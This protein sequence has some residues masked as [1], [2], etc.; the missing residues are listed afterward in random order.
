MWADEPP[1]WDYGRDIAHV[2][3]ITLCFPAFGGGLRTYADF[4]SE[5]FRIPGRLPLDERIWL[6]N[7]LHVE[8][9]QVLGRN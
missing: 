4:A 9:H 8:A 2:R 6:R 5:D 3:Q 1:D 7:W